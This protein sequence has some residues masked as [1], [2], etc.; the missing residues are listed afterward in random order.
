MYHAAHFV[1]ELFL[2]GQIKYD[3]MR[4][5]PILICQLYEQYDAFQNQNIE[6]L[7]IQF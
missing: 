1:I 3:Y 2:F 7:C 4:N 5:L 6:I